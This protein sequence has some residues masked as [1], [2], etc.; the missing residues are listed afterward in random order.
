MSRYLAYF[1]G[2]LCNGPQVHS[3]LRIIGE[4]GQPAI[5][6]WAYSLCGCPF[7]ISGSQT[8]GTGVG[9]AGGKVAGD[10][11]EK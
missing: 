6:V 1:R 10:R 11:T 4:V 8:I 5:R 9:N 2:Q 3:G 7:S